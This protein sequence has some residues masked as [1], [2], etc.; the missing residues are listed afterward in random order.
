MTIDITEE[1]RSLLDKINKKLDKLTVLHSTL[2][3]KCLQSERKVIQEL[4]ITRGELVKVSEVIAKKYGI[5]PDDRMNWRIN[6]DSGVLEKYNEIADVEAIEAE[7]V[8]EP[9]V[10]Q[11][12]RLIDDL[13][14]KYAS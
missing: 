13:I 14:K 3:E 4:E 5:D 7:V 11:D 2:R 12:A 1:D 10:D 6:L 9:P 8:E